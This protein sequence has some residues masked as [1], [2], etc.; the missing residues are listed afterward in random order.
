MKIYV[1]KKGVTMSD[2]L[3]VIKI[4]EVNKTNLVKDFLLEM[5]LTEQWSASFQ[6]V[7]IED[8]KERWSNHIADYIFGLG[9][10]E[11]S[12]KIDY[13]YKISSKGRKYLE[14]QGE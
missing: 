6:N 1:A 8:D 4:S 7:L 12:N 13:K 9:Y 2:A 10:V 11:K 3:R 5:L 14:Q